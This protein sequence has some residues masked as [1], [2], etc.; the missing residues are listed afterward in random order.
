MVLHGA[1]L[2]GFVVCVCGTFVACWIESC[3]CVRCKNIN[4]FC[5]PS[6]L[7]VLS[8]LS[9]LLLVTLRSVRSRKWG[10]ILRHKVTT[11]N[12]QVTD[13]TCHVHSSLC[14]KNHSPRARKVT[15]SAIKVYAGRNRASLIGKS[16]LQCQYCSGDEDTVFVKTDT[17]KKKLL[18]TFVTAMPRPREVNSK[19]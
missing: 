11:Y 16:L 9:R 10:G 19:M 14:L 4:S 15:H 12:F 17:S 8:F 5:S 18:V 2:V 6:L 3:T 1:A 7:Q 13:F